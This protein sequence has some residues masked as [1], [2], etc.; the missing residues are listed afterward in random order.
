[1]D[2][3]THSLKIVA[4]ASSED[5]RALLYKQLQSLE[6]VEF[7]GVHIELSDAVGKCHSF[8]PDVIIVDLSGR[9]LDGGLFIQAIGMNPE[10]PCTIF[11]LHREMDLDIF[12]E[13]VRRGAKE[14]IQ[15]PDD[16]QGLTMA[17]KKHLALLSRVA[18]NQKN[19]TAAAAGKAAEKAQGELLVVFSSKGGTGSSTIATNLAYEL[20]QL[21]HSVALFDMDQFYC[22][23]EMSLSVKPEYALGELSLN[24][25]SDVDSA[26]IDKI[27][28]KHES[29]L[30]V[31]V[32][33]KNVLEDN[34][35]I[36]A[37]LLE[38]IL[39]YLLQTY[40]YV[41]IDLPTGVLDPY[42]QYLVERA[43]SLL[44]VSNPDVPSLVRT[45]QYLDLAEKYLDPKKIKVILNRHNMKGAYQVS[46]NLQLEE[47][48]KLSVFHRITNDWDT[49]VEANSLGQPMSKI[50][51]KSEIAKSFQKLARLIT[52][53][54]APLSSPNSQAKDTTSSDKS[55]GIL[56]RLFAGKGNKDSNPP[57]A[58]INV[59][60]Q[61]K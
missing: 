11:A 50:N 61:A 45:R 32:G 21:T 47:K 16:Q 60:Q 18:T 57:G 41:V 10:N 54:E 15:Y 14:F 44:L 29:G 56:G 1:M 24:N 26:L 12:K 53:Q 7:E 58:P 59:I 35:M 28:A 40:R 4:V 30:H 36:P 5:T 55:G 8:Q 25:A 3:H 19:N 37:E 22:N 46:N 23:T 6:F 9:E 17:L 48:F 43:D 31:L 34:E 33:C 27:I 13:A 52:G 2:S 39:T 49:N 42:H 38:I 20:K 51:T